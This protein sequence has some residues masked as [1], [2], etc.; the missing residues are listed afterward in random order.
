MEGNNY[1]YYHHD[2][3]SLQDPSICSI[4]HLKPELNLGVKMEGSSCSCSIVVYIEKQEKQINIKRAFQTFLRDVK[5]PFEIIQFVHPTNS[6]N[7]GKVE[8]F[9]KQGI[10]TRNPQALAVCLFLKEPSDCKSLKLKKQFLK[11]PWKLDHVFEIPRS[12]RP[13]KIA[14]Q[15]F[16][17]FSNYLP[18]WSINTVHYGNEH[19][20]Y[21]IYV[22]NF[23]PMKRFYEALTDREA[24]HCGPSFCFLTIYSENGLDVQIGLKICSEVAP[25]PSKIY[26]LKFR[27][28]SESS[29]FKYL[30]SVTDSGEQKSYV[31]E[32]PDGN[33][34]IVERSYA[35][36][37]ESSSLPAEV[38]VEEADLEC[39][40]LNNIVNRT[41]S[42]EVD[43]EQWG[44]TSA[45]E[46]QD[47]DY[48]S[49]GPDFGRCSHKEQ[50][51][52]DYHETFD[53]QDDGHV[54]FV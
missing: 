9:E 1:R 32:D 50:N 33:E 10:L 17:S 22:R 15:E 13:R 21:H 52:S 29:L 6:P 19:L 18:L 48:G 7:N 46:L 54:T 23:R 53:Q 2:F 14:R 25:T 36:I 27:I 39:H 47:E 30:E 34:V 3:S 35:A 38:N 24:R 42:R 4:T 37:A 49:V 20:R 40:E 12:T 5:M 16:Y 11:S 44:N 51:G 45:A 26:R 28:Q 31:L 41:D 8:S 43:F